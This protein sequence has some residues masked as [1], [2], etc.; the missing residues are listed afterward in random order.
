MTA[1]DPLPSLVHS[2]DAVVSFVGRSRELAALRTLL[3]DAVHEGGLLSFCFRA[4]RVRK[5]RLVR[6]LAQEA[7][8]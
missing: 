7:G 8:D 2:A 5:S 4:S 6:E 3:P 1:G